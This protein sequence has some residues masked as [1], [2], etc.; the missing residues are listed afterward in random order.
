MILVGKEVISGP[1]DPLAGG[2]G[3]QSNSR[4]NFLQSDEHL[5][6]LTKE[7]TESIYGKSFIEF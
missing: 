2:D 6:G 3:I 4:T 7:E 5:K 1:V